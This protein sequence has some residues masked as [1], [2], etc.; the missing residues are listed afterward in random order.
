MSFLSRFKTKSES[1]PDPGSEDKHTWTKFEIIH[2][3]LFVAVLFLFF[4]YGLRIYSKHL[5]QIYHYDEIR[6]YMDRYYQAVKEE[7]FESASDYFADY[8][9]TNVSSKEELLAM[10]DDVHTHAGKLKGFSVLKLKA[11]G[12]KTFG[13]NGVGIYYNMTVSTRYEQQETTESFLIYRSMNGDAMGILN[14]R[15]RVLFA[16]KDD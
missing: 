15:V 9:Y 4:F 7:D 1:A 12:R 6:E 13:V 11:T 10:Y 8:F 5:E 14:I 2:T 16:N 3:V